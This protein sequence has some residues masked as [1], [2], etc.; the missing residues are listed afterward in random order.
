MVEA[1]ERGEGRD[2]GLQRVQRHKLVFAGVDQDRHPPPDRSIAKGFG[3]LVEK[4]AA[5]ER[6]RADQRIAERIME[7]GRAAAR[8]MDPDLL[9]SLEHSH[10]GARGKRGGRGQARDPASDD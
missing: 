4:G 6:Q 8:R 3:R 2:C 7:H 5:G 10:L 1:V 9:L